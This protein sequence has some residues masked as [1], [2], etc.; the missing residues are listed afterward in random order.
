VSAEYL[1]TDNF[2]MYQ[3]GQLSV[4]NTTER[5]HY[6]GAIRSIGVQTLEGSRHL[7]VNFLWAA[8]CINAFDKDSTRRQ[9]IRTDVSGFKFALE[10][11]AKISNKELKSLVQDEEVELF[12][13]SD[14]LINPEAIEGLYIARS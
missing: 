9:W 2:R 10:L 13:P 6:C 3:N 4:R 8:K 7:V 12:R 11:Y 1:T 14:R 5:Y